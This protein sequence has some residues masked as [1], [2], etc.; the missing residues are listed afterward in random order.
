LIFSALKEV[1]Q[2][3]FKLTIMKL[4]EGWRTDS[5]NGSNITAL[6]LLARADSEYKW[7][8]H[9]GQWTTKNKASELLHNCKLLSLS[10]PGL[11]SSLLPHLKNQKVPLNLRRLFIIN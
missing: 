3:A 7:L 10:T 5:G 4:Y 1:N 6:K 11:R 8:Q 9:L 2:D